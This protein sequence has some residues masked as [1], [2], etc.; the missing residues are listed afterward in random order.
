MP[1]SD[2][3]DTQRRTMT[4]LEMAQKL[5][6]RLAKYGITVRA[7]SESPHM[8]STGVIMITRATRKES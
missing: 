4:A 7:L 8:P 1:L 2:R 3:I 6:L 5:T